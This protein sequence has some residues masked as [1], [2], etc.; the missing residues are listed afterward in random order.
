MLQNLKIVLKYWKKW[1]NIIIL[2]IEQDQKPS[3]TGKIYLSN[4]KP[5]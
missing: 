2:K 4:T 3:N 1:K 5:F